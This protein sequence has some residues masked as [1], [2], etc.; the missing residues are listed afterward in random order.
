MTCG[1]KV[2]RW[3][4]SS[5]FILGDSGSHGRPDSATASEDFRLP[6]PSDK[7]FLL[8]AER[9][10][11]LAQVTHHT[12]YVLHYLEFSP[13]L[14]DILSDTFFNILSDISFDILSD[15]SFGML[16]TYLL[17]FFLWR[18]GTQHW[19]HGIAA[20]VR[21]A[22]LLSKD[23]GW[24]PARNTELTGS[25]LRSGT[26]HWSHRIAVEVRHATL[27]SPDRG[28]GPARNTDLTG[29]RWGPARNTDL[30]GSRLRS[31]TQHWSHR[32]AV[33]VRHATLISPDRGWGPARNTDLTGS[34][35]RSGTQHWS[36]RIA[37]EVRRATLISRDRGWGPARNTDLTGSRLRS[38]TQH[39]SHRIAVRSGTQHWSHRIADEVRHAT[40][41]SRDRGW[42]PARNTDLTGSRLRSEGGE[43]RGRRRRR[44]RKRR[45][46]QAD[47]KSNNPH[48]TGGEKIETTPYKMSPYKF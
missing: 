48:L 28:W 33:E 25:Q 43:G 7:S 9:L 45:R 44:R 6:R 36:H 22:T 32:I 10:S 21:H 35:L 37:V 34:R 12:Y 29:S 23:R 26:Q 3:G 18:S 13:L 17:T 4:L 16:V 2:V 47:I 11:S 14:S 39:W 27:I 1:V 46:R 40:L 15:I 5:S 8:F 38:G 42:G 20:E 19:T 31:G 30:T 41:I 24:G